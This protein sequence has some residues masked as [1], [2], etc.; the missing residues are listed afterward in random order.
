MN[1]IIGRAAKIVLGSALVLH[2]AACG[3]LMHPER[4]GQTQGPIDVGVA[5]L[6]GI[7]LLFFIIPGVIAYAVDF[8]NGTIYL[9]SGEGK[10]GKKAM[11]ELND[12]RTVR[13]DPRRA[14]WE[15]IEADVARHAG[16]PVVLGRSS[17]RFEVL[18]SKKEMLARF[19]A[20]R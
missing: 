4:K 7:G 14:S 5:I 18:A 3:T 6:D 11:L 15:D 10:K 2:A 12:L 9:P 8:S 1:G 16:N 17:E 13:F 20:L 19:E